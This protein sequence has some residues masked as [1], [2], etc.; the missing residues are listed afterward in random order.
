M[1]FIDKKEKLADLIEAYIVDSEKEKEL[2]ELI[3]D[4]KSDDD[5][6]GKELFKNIFDEITKF[7]PELSAKELKQRIL[8]IRSYID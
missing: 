2:L 5:F 6:L 1:D 3:D 8:M 4:Y 7:L